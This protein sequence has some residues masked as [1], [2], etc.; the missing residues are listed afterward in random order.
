MAAD[1]QI[2][3]GR[4]TASGEVSPS[5]AQPNYELSGT[6]SKF[7]DRHL[8]FPILEFHQEKGI[9]NATDI[10]Q[11]KLALLKTTNMVDFAMD[12]QKALTGSEEVPQEMRERRSAVVARLRQLQQDVD[13]IIKCLENPN[14]VRNFR[15][16]KAFN[17]Q[18]GEEGQITRSMVY[19]S[20]RDGSVHAVLERGFPDRARPCR[21][22][23]PV[24]EVPIRLWELLSGSR[25]LAPLPDALHQR[26]AKHVSALGK[27]FIRHFDAG[28]R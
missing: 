2:R 28:V 19:D 10:M 9:Y 25:A 13:P 23:V 14:V 7:L 21:S 4:A 11:A 8:V 6:L 18:V 17:L 26:R 3:T 1:N 27:A 12:I 5:M 22:L 20:N 24:C 15:Q 16:D